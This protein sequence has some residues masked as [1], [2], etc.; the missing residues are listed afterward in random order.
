LSAAKLFKMMTRVDMVHV[1]YRGAGPALADLLGGQVQLYF[2]GVASSVE[3][4]RAGKLRAIGITTATR[5]EA[6][7]IIPTGSEFV[8]GYEASDWFG[9]GAPKST[10]AEIVD[11][12]NEVVNAGLSDANLKARISELGGAII[13]GSPVDFGKLIA[14]ETQKWATVIKFAGIK[15]D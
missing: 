14:D 2:A 6:L 9:L 7:P 3:H 1:P 10:P 13:R 4:V 5:S 8:P 15:L 12:L 11:K